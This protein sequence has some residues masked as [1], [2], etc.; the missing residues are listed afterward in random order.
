MPRKSLDTPER[1]AMRS[2]APASGARSAGAAG[3]GHRRRGLGWLWAL[4]GLLALGLLIAAL[5]G[6]FSSGDDG[7]SGQG[8]SGTGAGA[9]TASGSLAA[10]GTALLPP[11]AGGLKSLVGKTATA[12]D[13]VV[14][15]VVQNAENPGTLEGFWV[16]S[17]ATDRVYVEWGGDVGQAEADYRPKVGEHVRLT[18]PVRPAP[19]NPASALR[20]DAD[21]A[22]L[23]RSQGGFVNA[24]DVKP[25]D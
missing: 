11:R 19:K 15:S 10:G 8:S 24:D 25:V 20:L 23:V 16:G 22:Q 18:G 14:Q 9:G 1:P 4:L 5:A 7:R 3:T 12:D 2:A 6:A 17:S 21:E 13:V